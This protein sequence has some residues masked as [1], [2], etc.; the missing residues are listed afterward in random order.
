MELYDL[1]KNFSE[2]DLKYIHV[3]IGITN[4]LINIDTNMS[5]AISDNILKHIIEIVEILDKNNELSYEQMEKIV[6]KIKN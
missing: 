3:L 5:D 2:K 4:N 1:E 6:D